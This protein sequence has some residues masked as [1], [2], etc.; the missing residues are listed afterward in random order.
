MPIGS[1]AFIHQTIDEVCAKIQ[2][3]LSKLSFLKSNLTKFLLQ[4]A[5]FGVCR[6]NHLLRSL[7]FAHG[8]SLALKS[9]VLFH[10]ALGDALGSAIPD[11]HHELASLPVRKGGLGLRNP[12]TV[13]GPAYLAS[14]FSFASSHE[15]LP[16]AFW[17]EFQEAW[18][19]IQNIA[20]L[21]ADIL[22]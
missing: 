5:C 11:I 3:L 20:G 10:D 13:L 14:N 21:Q 1:D 2:G 6:V 17:A 4:R 16:D 8:T 9:S 22:P 18:T 19:S 7:P 15:G 12:T